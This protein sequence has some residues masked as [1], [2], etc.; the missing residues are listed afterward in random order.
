MSNQKL[1][2]LFTIFILLTNVLLFIAKND[3][4]VKKIQSFQKIVVI[5]YNVREIVTLTKN[6]HQHFYA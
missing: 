3:I 1:R 5:T 2:T 6:T 4:C